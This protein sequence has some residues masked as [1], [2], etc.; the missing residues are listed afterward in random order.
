M[1]IIFLDMH[2]NNKQS[3]TNSKIAQLIVYQEF[4]KSIGIRLRSLVLSWKHLFQ[5]I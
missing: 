3:K 5:I 4:P 1:I 2:F